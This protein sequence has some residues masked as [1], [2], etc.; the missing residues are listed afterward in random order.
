MYP[1]A[2]AA[3]RGPVRRENKPADYVVTGKE[4]PQTPTLSD[5]HVH[6]SRRIN[7]L[8][9]KRAAL[10]QKLQS[11]W[12]PSLAPRTNK[13]C[14][15]LKN[16]WARRPDL[17]RGWRFCR[18]GL[19]VYLVDSSCFLVGPAPRF[20]PVFGRICSQIVP[21]PGDPEKA[22]GTISSP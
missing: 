3:S 20:S 22:R 12:R 17:N 9:S 1:V 7:T 8:H 21:T 11:I 4:V 16:L 6:N 15:F 19:D 10:H 2:G 13:R 14:R 5:L 18:L